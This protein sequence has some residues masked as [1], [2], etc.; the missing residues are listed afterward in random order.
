MLGWPKEFV[1]VFP[2]LW[3]NLNELFGQAKY[4]LLFQ[5]RN[6]ELSRFY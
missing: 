3:E 2:I 4:K 5:R 6:S 1:L